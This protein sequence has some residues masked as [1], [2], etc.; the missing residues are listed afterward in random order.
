MMQD[1][2]YYR[3]NTDNRGCKILKKLVCRNKNAISI[4]RRRNKRIMQ[5]IKIL[6]VEIEYNEENVRIKD[7]YKIRTKE[8]MK[9]ILTQFKIR[10]GFKSKRSI[11]SW[12]KEWKSHNRLYRLGLFRKHTVD[13]DLE[14]NEKFHRLIVYEI[15]GRF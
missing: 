9:L 8:Y 2:R 11:D 13:C 10:T 14:E 6:R 5:H 15:I 3:N 4:I 1:C 12:I 7:S